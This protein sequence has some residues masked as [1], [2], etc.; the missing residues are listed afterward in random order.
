LRFSFLVFLV[1]GMAVTSALAAA[2]GVTDNSIL[3]GS[4][5]ALDQV[6]ELRVHEDET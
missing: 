5:S 2:P 4:C 6:A 1:F 3:I